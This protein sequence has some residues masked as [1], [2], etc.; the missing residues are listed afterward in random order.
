MWHAVWLCTR[1]YSIRWHWIKPSFICDKNWNQQEIVQCP[2]HNDNLAELGWWVCCTHLQAPRLRFQLAHWK[3]VAYFP[4]FSLMKT[5]RCT[6]PIELIITHSFIAY[7]PII[8]VSA[9]TVIEPCRYRPCFKS[10]SLCHWS[11]LNCAT[12]FGVEVPP[13]IYAASGLCA[14]EY[15]EIRLEKSLSIY[16]RCN[17]NLLWTERKIGTHR[18]SQRV[19]IQKFRF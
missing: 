17:W 16:F 1:Y 2:V 5:S 9:P 14:V 11:S 4:E 12:R 7:P 18:P 6:Q 10:S 3:L 15:S 19:Q 13:I 8:I